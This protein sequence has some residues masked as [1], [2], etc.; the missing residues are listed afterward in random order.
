MIGHREELANQLRGKA[1]MYVALWSF[2]MLQ[3][4]Y[5]LS[6]RLQDPM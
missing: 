1:R 4:I 2:V 5:A 3:D 6:S